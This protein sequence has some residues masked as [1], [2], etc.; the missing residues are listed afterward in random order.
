MIIISIGLLF[1]SACKNESEINILKEEMAAHSYTFNEPTS[2]PFVVN[3]VSTEMD[4]KQVDSLHQFIFYYGNNETTQQLKYIVSRVVGEK[5]DNL[6]SEKD[7]ESSIEYTLEN[8]RTAYFTEDESS[9]SI[10]WASENGF[11]SRFMY[12]TNKNR[13][14]LGEYRL[15]VEDFIELANQVQ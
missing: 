11:L 10:W 9:Q 7:K 14:G 8:G 3:E 12:F 1:L 6:I 5:K 4:I 13:T 2:F 15:E